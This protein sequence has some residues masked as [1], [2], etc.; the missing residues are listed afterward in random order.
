[1]TRKKTTLGQWVIRVYGII[2]LLLFLYGLLDWHGFVNSELTTIPMILGLMFGTWTQLATPAIAL[3]IA[4]GLLT[5]RKYVKYLY[6]VVFVVV[7]FW[8]P[9]VYVL[10]DMVSVVIDLIILYLMFLH[11][12]TKKL[13]ED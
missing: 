4:Y 6:L 10:G 11:K 5:T 7:T 12:D 13:F 9:W 8:P 2:Y 3:A 1:M